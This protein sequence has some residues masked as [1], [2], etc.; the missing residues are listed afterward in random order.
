R[1]LDLLAGEEAIAV[2][3]RLGQVLELIGEWDEAQA[4]YGR[5]LSEA[6][7]LVNRGARARC[8]TA[9]GDLRRKRGAYGEAARWLAEARAG[10]EAFGDEAGVGQVLHLSGTLAAQQGDYAAARAYYRESLTIRRRLDDRP[11]IA[12]LLSN[13]GIIA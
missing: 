7:A 5:A 6:E 3:L 8:Q 2:R 11:R 10:F 13:L 9:I 4:S 1:A 12:A